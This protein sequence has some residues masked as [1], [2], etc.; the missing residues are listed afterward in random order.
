MT[1]S[2]YQDKVIKNLLSI[3]LYVPL[4]IATIASSMKL[5]DFIYPSDPGRNVSDQ[6][7]NL[8]YNF[9]NSIMLVFRNIFGYISMF[10]KLIWDGL[11]NFKTLAITI[12][13]IYII[14]SYFFTFLYKD[15]S[16]LKEWSTYY[17]DIRYGIYFSR[18][19]IF[20]Y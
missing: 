20:I 11:T 4:I 14:L 13:V 12:L 19:Y 8:R 2:G 9:T 7:S 16:I 1:R 18:R 17:Y 6:A 5:Y 15:N 3:T 10:F